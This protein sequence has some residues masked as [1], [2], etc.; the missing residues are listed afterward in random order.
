[1]ASLPSGA[2]ALVGK[3]LGQYEMLALL[4][5]G[6]T[7]EIYLARV[8][9]TAGFEKYVVVKCLHDHLAYDPEFVQM[10]LDEAR[11]GAQLGHSNIVQTLGLG[12]QDGRYYLVM[13]YVVGMSLALMA[14]RAVER[15]PRGYIPV[16]LVL[17]IAVQACDGLHYAH[18]LQSGGR[19]LNLVHR[20]IS[21]QNLVVTFE[22]VVKVVDFGIAKAEERETATR[23]GTIKGKF[24]YMS[25]EQCQARDIDRRTDVFALGVVLHELLT[26]RRL[27][28]RGS[29]YDTYQAIL[30]CKVPAPSAQN[31]ELDPALDPLL[32]KAL[33]KDPAQRYPSCEAFGEALTN[34]LHTRGKSAQAGD[35]SQFIDQ[36]YG[37]ELGDQAARMRELL[38]GR[39]T[40]AAGWDDEDGGSDSAMVSEVQ[41]LSQFEVIDELDGSGGGGGGG[42]IGEDDGDED[43]GGEEGGESTRIEM[44]PLAKL[45]ELDERVRRQSAQQP[46]V[47]PPAAAAAPPPAA[48]V[49]PAPPAP[50]S[51][52]AP[53]AGPPT[54]AMTPAGRPPPGPEPA[55][56]PAAP[57]APARPATQPV[58]GAAS[59]G[60][61]MF[62]GPPGGLKA[63]RLPTAPEPPR[64]EI[65]SLFGGPSK[66]APKPAPGAIA[67]GPALPPVPAPP[68]AKT[69]G[70]PDR[71][72][73]ETQPAPV[74]GK[75]FGPTPG[76]AVVP[77]VIAEPEPTP[78]STSSRSFALAPEAK[79]MAMADGGFVEGALAELRA[80]EARARAGQGPGSPPTPPP[81]GAA[82]PRGMPPAA[83]LQTVVP[84]EDA[85]GPTAIA[86]PR[87]PV[88]TGAEDIGR[89]ATLP[90]MG[91]AQPPGGVDPRFDPRSHAAPDQPT[92]RAPLVDPLAAT[93]PPGSYQQGGYPPPGAPGGQPFP[94]GELLVPPHG[95]PPGTMSP[96]DSLPAH[97]IGFPQQPYHPQGHPYGQGWGDHTGAVQY[98]RRLP[99]WVL[100]VVFVVA[101]G[102]AT[103]ITIALARALG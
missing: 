71:S 98:R 61:S 1:M 56:A 28:K 29:A 45:A 78:S 50:A 72:K 62:G 67:P 30:E 68:A 11:L 44:N 97:L 24:A 15:V 48:A 64:K 3:R 51:S 95:T 21:P 92:Y 25:P 23:S 43:A 26:G 102:L 66:L 20:D 59:P 70:R 10:F 84:T 100:P 49:A 103:G 4:A 86:G 55:P 32:L 39:T 58:F 82:P 80:A 18:E 19:P 101:I 17:G 2:G 69:P 33:A 75:P 83:M 16:P 6:G 54:V 57:S 36:Y 91:V 74:P 38:A 27:F 8:G 65:P 22:G 47:P 79:T 35:I 94:S 53:A 31:H 46:A 37:P 88:P 87:V 77:T 5:L 41:E 34:Y 60:G 40:A 96:H 85:D 76:A 81:P 63:P 89:S 99:T 90:A 9:G 93:P 13:E 52:T 7:A 12:E 42:R 73:S 14:R